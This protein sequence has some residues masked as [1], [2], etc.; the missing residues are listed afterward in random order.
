MT[1]HAEFLYR[2]LEDTIETDLDRGAGLAAL[3]APLTR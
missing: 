3:R 1:R 2:C